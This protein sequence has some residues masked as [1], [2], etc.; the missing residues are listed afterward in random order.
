MKLWRGYDTQKL[1]A[2]TILFREIEFEKR[3]ILRF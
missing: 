2:D 1:D 3:D